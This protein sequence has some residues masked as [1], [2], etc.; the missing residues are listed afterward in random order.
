[1]PFA[2]LPSTAAWQHRQGREGFEVAFFQ[3]L[4]DGCRVIGSTAAAEAGSTWVVEYE[5]EL[6]GRW[7]TRRA[8]ITGRSVL[9]VSRV[10]LEADGLGHWLVDGTPVAHLDGCLDID[11]ESSALTN[12]FPVHR[13]ALDVGQRAEVPAAYVRAMGLDV[14]RLE[15]SY[16]RVADGNRGQRYDYAAPDFEFACRLVYDQHGLLLEYPGIAVRAA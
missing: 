2:S 13:L 9:G 1:M 6:D 14:Q 8:W 10:V 11:L 4:D 3:V 5:I 12:A 7:R 16:A 15:Q